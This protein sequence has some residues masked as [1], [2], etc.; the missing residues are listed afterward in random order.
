MRDAFVGIDLGTSSVK[1][2]II[3]TDGRLLGRGKERT[4]KPGLMPERHPLAWY[5]AAT[6]ACKEALRQAPA[7]TRVLAIAISGNGPTLVRFGS[8]SM[9]LGPA[10]LWLDK[11]PEEATQRVT[12][13]SG[14]PAD[15]SF[16]LPKA[17]ATLTT[18]TAGFASGPEYLASMFGSRLV[19]YLSHPHF[20]PYIWDTTNAVVLGLRA[21]LF[22]PYVEPCTRIGELNAQTALAT[23][24]RSGT[25]IVSAFPDFLAALVG[26][27]TMKAG[28]ACDRTGSS[29]ALNLC[30]ERPYPGTSLFS[31]PHPAPGLWNV[32]GG[33]STAGAALEWYQQTCMPQAHSAHAVIEAAM[34][35]PP[36]AGGLAFIPYLDGERAPLRMPELRAAFMGLGSAS[37]SEHLA[38]AVAESIA[39][40]LR[41]VAERMKEDD[42]HISTVRC[43][44]AMALSPWLCQLKADV[45]GLPA[46]VPAVAEAE[47]MGDACA[48]S[49]ALGLHPNL[50]VASQA[51]VQVVA[52]YQPSDSLAQAY[53]S[54]YG[55]WKKALNAA[56]S[57][58]PQGKPL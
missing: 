1:A 6:R 39:Y 51:L 15:S 21:S 18:D 14:R 29:E 58:I 35:A 49:V 11:A 26:S 57:L 40:A 23:G 45:L 38:R 27:G 3:G 10:M 48:C 31:L 47:A 22:P 7:D 30:Y 19:S 44:G 56:A 5:T 54:A 50:S 42:M 13:A 46:E 4:N 32:S 9:P 55:F 20:E 52:R 17:L 43:T 34:L 36:G 8:D 33:L 41:L 28:M 37:K 16:Y 24:L 12:A 25:P 53:D 2:L